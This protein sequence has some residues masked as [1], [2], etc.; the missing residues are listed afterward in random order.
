MNMLLEV[1][2]A[3]FGNCIQDAG[4]TGY[5]SIGVPVSGAADPNLLACANY[6]LGNDPAAP[7][8]EV[9]LMGPRLVAVSGPLRCAL[10]G[11]IRARL[12]QSNGTTREIDQWKTVTLFEGDAISVGAAKGPGYI[13]VSGGF[14]VPS[15]LGSCS[16][17]ARAGLGGVEGRALQVGDRIACGRVAG[18]P[19]LEYRA[20][21]PFEHPGG[22][23]RVI[24][25][26]Q[27][28]FFTAE[29]VDAFF[30][31]PF[32]VTA[33]LDRMGIRLEGPLL[34]HRADKGADIL[35]DGITPGAIQVPASGQPIVLG[36][37]CQ[38]VGGYPKIATLISADVPRLSHLVPGEQIRFA[39]ATLTEAFLARKGQ[40][41][42]LDEWRAAITSFR[43]PGVI[44]E[45]ALYG[46]NLLSGMINA[47]D[48]HRANDIDLP[49]E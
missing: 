27:D 7:G 22:A 48:F 24:V 37:D 8:I 45:A 28:D 6:L 25:G 40:R 16:T 2:E 17:Y 21:A 31:Q 3:G 39:P 20:K 43:P 15:Q 47:R 1:A 32:T 30:S 38:T 14:Q 41:A 5:R 12:Y 33:E 49:W 44:D 34:T 36:P 13:G 23:F 46:E 18:D 9:T 4:R 42:S 35:S 10:V 29:A 26:P 11:G 19:F